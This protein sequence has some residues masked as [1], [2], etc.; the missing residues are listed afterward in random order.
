[1]DVLQDEHDGLAHTLAHEH[2]LN[3]VKELPLALLWTDALKQVVLHTNRDDI[4]EV[5]DYVLKTR[6]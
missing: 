3:N 5:G 4:A 1:M 2:R 6:C